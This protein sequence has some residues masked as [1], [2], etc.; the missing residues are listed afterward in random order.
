MAYGTPPDQ[1]SVLE[2][3]TDVRR[4]RPPTP[5][6]LADLV[7]RYE[8]IGGLS[9]MNERTNAQIDALQLALDEIAPA[10]YSTY[11][12]AKHASPKIEDAVRQAVADGC[13]ALVGLVLAPHY[14]A[15]SVGEYIERAKDTANQLGLASEFVERWNDEPALIDALSN[16]VSDA[17]ASLTPKQR[18]RVSVVMTAH[19]LPE[20]I[21]ASG[22]SYP[23]EIA[24]TARLIA[25]RL[26]LS[27]WQ[28]GWQS[29]GRTTEPWLGP[30]IND[31]IRDL[32][33]NGSSAVVVCACGFTSDHLEVLYDL[34]ILAKSVA[35]DAGV[36]FA[37][38]ASINAE[39]SVFVAL[40]R[41][42]VALR[43]N[44]ALR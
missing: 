10:E 6:Q 15:F 34:D 24:E 4:G 20:R 22:D 8:A 19:S 27:S 9:P 13:D 43:E 16:R 14:S 36:G 32:A 41:R 21:L 7:S 26:A 2:F 1:A 17:I 5:E 30:D 28:T 39:P 18:E 38:T 33:A 3:Y 12:G 23:D 35:N 44:L 25:E 31:T 37:R 11:Y 29:A 40:A 42:V